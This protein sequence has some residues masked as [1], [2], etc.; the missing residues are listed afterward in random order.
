[1]SK[2]LLFLLVTILAAVNI[3]N[4]Q[5]P[6]HFVGT[7]A[8]SNFIPFGAG[9]WSDQRCQYLYLPGEFSGSPTIGFITK[10]YWRASSAATGT[11]SNF[12]IAIGQNATTSLTT[13]WQTGLTTVYTN[14]AEPI[15]AVTGQWFSFTLTTPFFYDPSLPLIIDTKQTATSGGGFGLANQTA[16]GNRRAYGPSAAGTASGAGA[17]RYDFGFDLIA[18]FPC[19]GVPTTSVAGPDSA[20]VDSA[21]NLSLSTFYTGVTRQWQKSTNGINWTNFTGVI[22]PVT[23]GL[24]DSIKLKTYYR[25]IVT[26][27]ATGQSYTTPTKTVDIN[28]FYFCYCNNQGT[29]PATVTNKV[30]IGNVKINTVPADAVRLANQTLTGSI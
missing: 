18:G 16:V 19:T 26:C 14:P 1:M 30:N 20:C 6:Q 15:T 25:C 23:G 4:A 17:Q 12:E 7:G 21:F 2:K 13:T 28:P 10:V 24:R 3:V 5:V 9:G 29:F 27:T 22:N 11:Y 8:G